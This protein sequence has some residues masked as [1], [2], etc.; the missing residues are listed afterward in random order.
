MD[1]RVSK[2]PVCG[3]TPNP[4]SARAKGNFLSY[5]GTDY[6]FCC[7]GCKTKFEADPAKYL[8]PT[9][10]GTD[11]QDHNRSAGGQAA[12]GGC[13]GDEHSHH[14]HASMKSAPIAGDAKPATG[15][16]YTCPM[17]PE[18]KNVGPGD[19]PICGMALEPLDPAAAQDTA[20]YDGMLQRFWTSAIL[21][22]PIFAIVMFGDAGS[23]T[24]WVPPLLRGSFQAALA[25]PVVFWAA[26][27]LLVRGWKGAL[28]GHANMFTLIGLGV[29]V[30]FSY[31]VFALLFPGIV[32]AGYHSA[33][34]LPPL[35]FES[36]TVIV[37]L[38]LLGQVL[39]LRARAH[40]GKAVRALLDLSPKT[41]QRR[42]AHGVEEVSLSDVKLGD[43]L[44][45]RPG[46]SVSVDGA[47]IE[48]ESA[49]D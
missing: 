13:C 12:E 6:F 14:D 24:T 4:D 45:V 25:A 8:K 5:Q 22:M 21:S 27:P 7:G 37:T 19:C 41:A 26:W 40:T 20:E 29:G 18:V 44:L 16:I 39:E 42:T 33:S 1:I 3:M 28:S 49:V 35:Y 46:D 36:A 15:V 23:F 32:P 43:E 30:A 17:H 11:P 9:S 38:V 10:H 31:S 34:G 2:D 48:G 47:V